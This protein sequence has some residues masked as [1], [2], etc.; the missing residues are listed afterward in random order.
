MKQ[1]EVNTHSDGVELET[2]MASSS[3]QFLYNSGLSNIDKKDIFRFDNK[4]DCWK[5]T[6]LGQAI[7]NDIVDVLSGYIKVKEDEI[8]G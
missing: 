6:E 3:L 2:E 1:I 8:E 4:E 5:Y 7:F